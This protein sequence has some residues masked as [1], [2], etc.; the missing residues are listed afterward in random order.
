MVQAYSIPK[1]EEAQTYLDTALARGSKRAALIKGGLDRTMKAKNMELERFKEIRASL[2]ESLS[3]IHD[4]YPSFDQM[5]EFTKQL[6][7]LDLEVGR[8]KQALGGINSG[9]TLIKGLTR[10][11]VEGIKHASSVDSVVRTRAAY[12]GRVSSVMR[13]MQ[14]HLEVLNNAREIFRN[15]P[16]IDDELFTVAIAGFPNVGKSTLLSKMTSAKP[17]IKP[18]AFTTKGLNVGYF[19]YKYNKIQLIDTPGTLNRENPNPIERKADA[20]IKYLAQVIIYVFDPTESG[21]SLEQQKKL[22]SIV[23]KTEKTILVYI[24]KTD[25]APKK[26]VEYVEKNFENVFTDPLAL[27]KELI[28]LF[29]KEFA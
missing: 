23:K 19:E 25:I 15:L 12:I 27:R 11:H 28:I 2:T 29:K 10:E 6:F 4:A 22:Y 20:T 26:A 8:V 3:R 17:E 21:Y 5:S 16:T 7:E 24:S 14:K 9:M 18:Y 13:Q 1:A